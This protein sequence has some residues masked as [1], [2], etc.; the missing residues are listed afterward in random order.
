MILKFLCLL[1]FSVFGYLFFAIMY[2]LSDSEFSKIKVQ[3]ERLTYAFKNQPVFGV[4]LA[5]FGILENISWVGLTV[6]IV[7]WIFS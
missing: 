3:K 5:I 4:L 6:C 1:L 7:M 2:G